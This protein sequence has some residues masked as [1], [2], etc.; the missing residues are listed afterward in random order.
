[1]T[2]GDT[3]GS[4]P[5]S[6]PPPSPRNLGTKRALEGTHLDGGQRF[7]IRGHDPIVSPG[8]AP[9]F[10]PRGET[11]CRIRCWK[12]PTRWGTM[13]PRQRRIAQPCPPSCSPSPDGDSSYKAASGRHRPLWGATIPD[14]G[15]RSH[16]V[17][18]CCR[19]RGTGR[20]ACPPAA[21]RRAWRPDLREGGWGTAAEFGGQLPTGGIGPWNGSRR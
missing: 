8:V 7:P 5:L 15:T 14:Q 17:P 10:P 1:M 2:P 6:C 20:N 21:R 9:V 3:M 13:I 11:G 12:A 18:W 19:A 4:C 16:R